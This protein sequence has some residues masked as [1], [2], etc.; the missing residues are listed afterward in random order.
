VFRFFLAKLIPFWNFRKVK[1]GSYFCLDSDWAGVQVPLWARFSS[2]RR[3]DQFWAHSTPAHWAWRTL[4]N[5]N[6]DAMLSIKH[7][8]GQRRKWI[9][10]S[11][12]LLV[13]ASNSRLV[14]NPAGLMTIFSLFA[15]FSLWDSFSEDMHNSQGPH[16]WSS[17]QSSWLQMQGS[18]VR[19]PVTTKNK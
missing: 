3:P 12:L 16:L 8:G 2:P 4:S 19:F 9:G 17:G 15:A 1:F 6:R 11:K 14:S 5:I 7:N 18:R 10:S 13:V